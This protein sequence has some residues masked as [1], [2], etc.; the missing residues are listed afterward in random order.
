MDARLANN[1]LQGRHVGLEEELVRVGNELMPS[2][3]SVPG[4]AV[5]CGSSSPHLRA[6]LYS[7]LIHLAG[8]LASP[9]R[10]PIWRMLVLR[11]SG[12][13]LLPA[14]SIRVHLSRQTPTA[15]REKVG[16]GRPTHST[17]MPAFPY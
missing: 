4:F 11:E 15:T 1:G 8:A 5:G 6:P 13:C 9:F 2:R 12:A 7:C 14:N 17:G 10:L 16:H 3:F